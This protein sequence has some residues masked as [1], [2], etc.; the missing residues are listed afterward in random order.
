[1]S[2]F[3][4]EALSYDRWFETKMG[5]HA[6]HVETECAMGLFRPA[7]GMKILDVGCGTGNFSLKLARLGCL[8]TGIDLSK[9]MLAAAR[10]K[11]EK[12]SLSMDF[13]LM[14]GAEMTFTDETFDGVVSIAAFEF[15]KDRA[16]VVDEIFRVMK[17]GAFFLLGTI[18][19][20]SPWGEMYLRAGTEPGSLF[21]HARLVTM[22]ELK[23]FRPGELQRTEECLFT[24]PDAPDE[25]LTP[26][27]E[28]K[29]RTKGKGGFLWALWIKS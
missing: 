17:K 14:D 26:E 16:R 2:L 12:E 15:M 23:G 8:V 18:N 19:R 20:E 11:A 28:A 9:K 10:E 4:E 3:D 24:P 5:R 27:G 6:D 21:S 13:H 29:W 7:G 1:M 22:G 25:D